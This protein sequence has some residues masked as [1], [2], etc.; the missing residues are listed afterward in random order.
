L[1]LEIRSKLRRKSWMT[2]STSASFLILFVT[3]PEF[4]RT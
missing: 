1:R 4:G 3:Q 2:S